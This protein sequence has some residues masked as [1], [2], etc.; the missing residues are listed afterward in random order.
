MTDQFPNPE[1]S[2]LYSKYNPKRE[3]NHLEIVHNRC[4]VCNLSSSEHFSNSILF[5]QYIAIKHIQNNNLL[6]LAFWGRGVYQLW[7][8]LDHPEI[9]STM[10]NKGMVFTQVY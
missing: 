7:S 2:Y 1:I 8:N 4:N 6:G 10:W 3:K 9:A 5:E